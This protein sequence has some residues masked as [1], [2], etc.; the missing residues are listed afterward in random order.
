MSTQRATLYDDFIAWLNDH[1]V[2]YEL[3]EVGPLRSRAR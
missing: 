2:E 1:S 3:H